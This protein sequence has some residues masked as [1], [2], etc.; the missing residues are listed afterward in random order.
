ME[1]RAH[2]ALS[3]VRPILIHIASGYLLLYAQAIFLASDVPACTQA[4]MH[5]R[6]ALKVAQ[7]VESVKIDQ[8][9]TY[10]YVLLRLQ[11]LQSNEHSQLLVRGSRK[12]G[13]HR[14]IVHSEQQLLANDDYKVSTHPPEYFVHKSADF[15]KRSACNL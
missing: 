7:E 3:L 14:D 15:C 2:A 5:L 6:C 8:G 10:K 13:Y 12:A 11:S 9:G 1:G 4:R